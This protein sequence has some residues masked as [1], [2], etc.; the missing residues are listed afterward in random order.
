M[1]ENGSQSLS[2]HCALKRG[3]AADCQHGDGL[4]QMNYIALF[5]PCVK[6]CPHTGGEIL[7]CYES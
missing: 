2:T 6:F 3:G 7:A 4:T 1:A 5:S